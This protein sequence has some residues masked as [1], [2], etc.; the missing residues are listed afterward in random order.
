MAPPVDPTGPGQVPS[1]DPSAGPEPAAPGP[2]SGLS[3]IERS[4][5]SARAQYDKVMEAFKQLQALRGELDKLTLLG[6]MVSVEDVGK[7]ASE[8]V[9]QGFGPQL[10]RA[11]GFLAPPDQLDTGVA[12]GF[13]YVCA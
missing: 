8:L 3:P 1:A 2:A 9:G 10:G 12:I 7:G 6:D 13:A 11:A 5:L 4:H